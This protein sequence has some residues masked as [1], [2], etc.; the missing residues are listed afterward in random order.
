M[1]KRSNDFDQAGL[2]P[3]D[4]LSVNCTPLTKSIDI[5]SKVYNYQPLFFLFKLDISDAYTV[6]RYLK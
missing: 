4:T 1:L 5:F 3:V 6:S 2:P